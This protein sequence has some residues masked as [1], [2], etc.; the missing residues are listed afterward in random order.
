[1]NIKLIISIL[2][3][4]LVWFMPAEWIPI[5]HDGGLVT[6]A[7][8]RTLAIFVM[9]VCMWVLEP[10]P[11]FA[12]SVL[13]I[14]SEL[15]L[16][17]NKAPYIFRLAKEDAISYKEIMH[18]FAA[19]IILLFLGGFFLA[20]AATKYRLD[21][22]LARVMLRPFGSKPKNVMLGLMIITAIFSMFMS[23]TATTAMM[24]AVLMPVLK[25]VDVKD[26]LRI[27]LL[28]A[29][30]FAANIGGVGTPI[31]T[32]PNAVAMQFLTK[33]NGMFV[34]FGGWMAFA[35]PYVLVMLAVAW[36]VL[37][38]FF[39]PQTDRIDINMKGRFLKTNKAI[40]VYITF[41]VTILLWLS[42]KW[43]GMSSHTVAMLPVALFTM[44]GIITKDDL[45]TLSWDVLWLVSGGIAL[46]L[47]LK[48][49]GL[50]KDLVACIPFDSIP[51]MLVVVVACVVALL[52]ST[53]MSNT[54]TANLLLPIMV[55]L[56]ANA[57]VVASLSEY[58]GVLMLLIS[59]AMTCSLAMAMPISTPPNAIAYASGLIETKDMAKAGGVIGVVGMVGIFLLMFILNTIGFF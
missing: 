48:E 46:G 23:N 50:S 25:V 26:P 30:P 44:T 1:M 39:K 28:L 52:M 59:V 24:I 45:K 10:I 16:L 14:V 5:A 57:D 53:F 33:E 11:I 19:P 47:A 20:M 38:V 55:A 36:A 21:T 12:T 8:Q 54:A 2:L 43:H 18:T 17:S 29:I 9:A 3:P 27:G 15:L 35:V 37:L 31:G 6:V 41:A 34:S 13:V 7:E 42:G 40:V 4:L 56:A 22:N 32:P 49:T 58:G 51:A